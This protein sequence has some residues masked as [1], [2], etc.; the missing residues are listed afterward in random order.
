MHQVCTVTHFA[1]Y[2]DRTPDGNGP[3]TNNK[4]VLS[5]G[6]HFLC[7]FLIYATKFS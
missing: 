6:I 7:S 1:L 2:H 5:G 3:C 4:Q